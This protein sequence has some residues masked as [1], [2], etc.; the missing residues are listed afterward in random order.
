LGATDVAAKF[1]N[2]RAILPRIGITR[3]NAALHGLSLRRKRRRGPAAAKHFI[4]RMSYY[5]KN[6]HKLLENA[7]VRIQETESYEK[8]QAFNFT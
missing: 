2:F 8:L 5:Y 3:Q 1:V 6:G 4:I 7:E